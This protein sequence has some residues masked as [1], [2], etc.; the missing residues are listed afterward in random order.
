MPVRSGSVAPPQSSAGTRQSQG[1]SHQVRPHFRESHAAGF[2]ARCATSTRARQLAAGHHSS[3]SPHTQPPRFCRSALSALGALCARRSLR[4]ALS[5]LG[6]LCAPCSLH[7]ALSALG[8]PCARCARRSLRSVLAALGARC[9]RCS[10]RSALAALA[11]RSLRSLGARYAR[12]A[13]A[14]LAR[15]SL[16]SLDARCR[17]A[18]ATTRLSLPLGAL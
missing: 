11:R 7:S 4:S 3:R 8:A 2:A 5:A 13:L 12:S 10:L 15:R 18:F 9:A 17:S 16:R 1:R 14:A 6:A